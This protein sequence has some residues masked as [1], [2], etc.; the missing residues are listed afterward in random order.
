MTDYQIPDFSVPL[1]NGHGDE[2]RQDD[3]CHADPHRLLGEVFRRLSVMRAE[4]GEHA[5]GRAVQAVLVALGGAALEEAE[6]R[7]RTLRERSTFRSA[8][9]RVTAAAARP[10]DADRWDPGDPD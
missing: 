2:R 10:F 3:P 8:D 9:V 5:F 1:G 4:L 7:A 6:R